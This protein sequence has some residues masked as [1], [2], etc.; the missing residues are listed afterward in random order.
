MSPDDVLVVLGC[1]GLLAE[2]MA[3]RGVEE[4]VIAGVTVAIELIFGGDLGV[5][6]GM[7]C[8]SEGGSTDAES[9]T[10]GVPDS[11]VMKRLKVVQELLAEVRGWREGE[12]SDQ[13]LDRW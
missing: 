1:T 5:G 10:G 3:P 2:L 13:R 11:I 6:C 4:V 9:G 12:L 8:V 7:A